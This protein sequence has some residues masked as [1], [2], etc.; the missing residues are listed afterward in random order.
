MNRFGMFK[1][2]LLMAAFLPFLATAEQTAEW[3]SAG[4][5]SKSFIIKDSGKTRY[6]ELYV[7]IKLKVNGNRP[8]SRLS[9]AE[10][11]DF[12]YSAHGS[13]GQVFQALSSNDTASSQIEAVLKS[14]ILKE[15]ND[16]LKNSADGFVVTDVKF[17]EYKNELTE[18]VLVLTKPLIISVEAINPFAGDGESLYEVSLAVSSTKPTSEDLS[19]HVPLIEGFLLSSLS[20]F[21]E[22]DFFFIRHFDGGTRGASKVQRKLTT[23]LSASLAGI[24]SQETLKSL[25]VQIVNVTSI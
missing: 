23:S 22:S 7:T 19:F 21:K 10:K 20:E 1:I 17:E 11:R 16:T 2:A 25:R 3:Y 13:I 24:V 8:I 15:T 6:R 18:E 4:E 14:N 9:E 5:K 12:E